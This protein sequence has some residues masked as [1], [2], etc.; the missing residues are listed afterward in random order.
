[1]ARVHEL[2]ITRLAHR[3]IRGHAAR[4]DGTS[5]YLSMASPSAE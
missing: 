1:V 4:N 5:L 3:N 2:T